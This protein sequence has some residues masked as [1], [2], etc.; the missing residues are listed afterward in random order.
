M[1]YSKS[2]SNKNNFQLLKFIIWIILNNSELTLN[3]TKRAGKKE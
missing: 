3:N 2:Y 1:N